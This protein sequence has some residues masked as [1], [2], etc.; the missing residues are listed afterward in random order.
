MLGNRIHQARR[1]AGLTQ[2]ELAAAL[3][4][5]RSAVSEIEHGRRGVSAAELFVAARRLGKELEYFIAETPEDAAPRDAFPV[6]FRSV[7]LSG[8]DAAA[9]RRFQERCAAYGWLEA[10]LNVPRLVSP[11]REMYP[12]PRSA[13][14]A[15]EQGARLASEE[16]RRLALGV[17]PL[18][19]PFMIVESQGIRLILMD[20]ATPEFSGIAHSSPEWGECILVNTAMH[21]NRRAFDL[22][23][24]YCHVLVDRAEAWHADVDDSAA[25]RMR[26]IRADAFAAGF[27][28]PGEGV[29]AFLETRGV[30]PG[31]AQYLDVFFV[32]VA[33]GSSYEATLNRLQELGYLTE[34]H[35]RAYRTARNV[36]DMT[37]RVRAA[38]GVRAP[39]PAHPGAR[40]FGQLVM[41]AYQQDLISLGR[42]AELLDLDPV[43]AREL[44]QF[45]EVDE[46]SDLTR[47]AG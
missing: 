23:H 33:F 18:L 43:A 41:R 29:S 11:R 13:D 3:E 35:V 22:L 27:L 24:E 17:D 19:D 16:R 8:E 45:W 38:E 28:L 42:V 37:R 26:E 15:R 46:E 1:E 44:A 30:R 14:E 39:D 20:L 12:V 40:R 6:W 2:E 9:V 5:P 21:P 34:G 10:E 32:M 36:S 25:S 4:I 7:G 47:L 31:A